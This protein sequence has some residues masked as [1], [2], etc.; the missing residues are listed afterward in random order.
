MRFRNYKSM[1]LFEILKQCRLIKPDEA[2][3]ERSRRA[4][5]ASS[6]FESQT[7]MGIFKA[8]RFIFR[9]VETGAA[10]AL[11][12]LFIVL[13]MGGFSGTAIAPVRFSAIDPKVLRAEAQA[14]DAQIN[15]A[16][17][18]YSEPAAVAESTQKIADSLHKDKNDKASSIAPATSTVS[19][20]SS[21][22][23]V[24]SS[25]SSSFSSSTLSIDQALEELTK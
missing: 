19:V 7:S 11:A 23:D 4:V 20:P 10:L 8:R 1:E 16:S 6:Q 14:I 18:N 12:G 22:N 2:F 3:T 5:L 24:S 21:T 13:I 15:L 17:L 9:F 25:F